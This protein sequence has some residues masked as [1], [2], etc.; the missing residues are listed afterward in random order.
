M[1]KTIR[2]SILRPLPGM[3]AVSRREF[4]VGAGS[5]LLLGATGCGGGTGSSGGETTSEEA[6]TIEHKYGNTEIRGVP[7]RIVSVGFNDQDP[8]LAL[9]VT[10]VTVRDWFGDQPNAVW[11]WARD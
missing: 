2:R 3:N 7:G 1:T 11:P 5:L 4:L 8:I 6:R 10:P 9:G